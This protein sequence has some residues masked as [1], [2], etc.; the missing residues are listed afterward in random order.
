MDYLLKDTKTNFVLSGKEQYPLIDE[1][2]G[3]IHNIIIN[4]NLLSTEDSIFEGFSR[5]RPEA[6]I[7]EDDPSLIL[8]T[9]GTTGKPKGAV[10]SQKN[11]IHDAENIIHIWDITGNDV[12]CHCLPLF[13]IHGLCFALHTLLL[14]GGR[15]L[16]IDEFDAKTVIKYLANNED[17]YSCTVFMAVPAM[18]VKMMEEMEHIQLNFDHLRLLTSG[19]APLLTSDFERIKQNF[20]KEPVEREGMTET[21]MNFSNPLHGEKKPGSIGIPLPN[22]EVRIVDP[23][24]GVDVEKGQVAEFWLKSPSIIS[25]Y[26]NK[27]EETQ[28]TFLDEW[29]KTGD[30]GKVDKDGYYYLTDRIKNIIIS[31]GENISPKEI[32]SVINQIQNVQESSV[33]GIQ[34]PK[35]GE[36]V[37]AVVKLRKGSNISEDD[38]KDYCKT[39]LHNWKCPKDVVFVSELPKNKMGKVLKHEVKKIF[40]N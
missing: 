26:W 34:D 15:I 16:M 36:K 8:Y 22:L 12:L 24:T 38:V 14:A 39:H 33:V 1:I 6:N 20:G 13:H 21:G 7:A 37:V 11:L 17:P 9:S 4:T 32:E 35:W 25:R 23:D 18:Y 3:D 30:L 5:K 19:S 27:P 31:G 28:K 40:S 2:G 10:L 29:F